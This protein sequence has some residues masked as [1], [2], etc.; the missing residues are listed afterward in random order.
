LVLKNWTGRTNLMIVRGRI[1]ERGKLGSYVASE[2]PI[3]M[4]SLPSASALAGVTND[5][6]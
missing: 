4:R 3:F 5:R 2:G 1:T 6:S